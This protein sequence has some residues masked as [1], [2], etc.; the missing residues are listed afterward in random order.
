MIS[1]FSCQ[2][3]IDNPNK[4]FIKTWYDTE[5]IV[6]GRTTLEINSD[7]TFNYNA[8]GC[9]WR[10][11]SKGNWKVVGNTIE[12]NSTTIDSCYNM[13]P[14]AECI[15]FGTYNTKKIPTTVPNCS[16]K[17]D[18]EFTIFSK[19]IFYLKSDSLVYK[20]KVNSNCTDSIKLVFS[21]TEKIKRKPN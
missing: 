17:T 2:K 11:F 4:K 16:P 12:L 6:P 8:A 10:C 14:F 3:K 1:F 5:Y 7:C 9:Q 13:F 20:R 19:E 18:I 21:H 15:K